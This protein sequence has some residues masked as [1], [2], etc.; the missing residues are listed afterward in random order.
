MKETQDATTFTETD[1]GFIHADATSEFTGNQ[2]RP[3]RREWSELDRLA[4][5]N[6]SV[7]GLD[8]EQIARIEKIGFEAW[9]DQVTGVSHPAQ[10]LAAAPAPTQ[11]RRTRHICIRCGASF[12]AKRADAEFC[13]GRCRAR[14][15]RH[16]DGQTV[17]DNPK[18]AP[19][20][21]INTGAN[22]S[23]K[24]VIKRQ[25]PGGRI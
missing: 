10:K 21:R 3:A 23:S 2:L 13:S 15:S 4:G 25:R 11:S 8:S 18:P 5:M 20:T 12:L 9:F 16:P 19:E 1:P 14:A 7:T 17:T 22:D 6:V 24:D